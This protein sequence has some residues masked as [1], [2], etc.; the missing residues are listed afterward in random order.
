RRDGLAGVHPYFYPPPFLLGAPIAHVPLTTAYRVWFW[1]DLVLSVVSVAFL[2]AAWGRGR[3]AVPWLL[4]IAFGGA[5]AVANNHGMGQMNVLTLALVA[6]GLAA[7]E[8]DRQGLAGVL[9]GV[10]C[11]AKMS[12]A[13]FVAWWMLRG[14]YKAVGAAVLTGVVLS[15]AAFAVVPWSVQW[16]FYTGVLPG[17]GSGDYNGLSVP[18]GLFG[19]HAL[20]DLYNILLP[21]DGRTLSPVARLLS[22]A[23]LVGVLA[24]M[25][26]AF[27]GPSDAVARSGQAAAVAVAML[28]V[29]VYTYEHHLVWALPAAVVVVDAALSG[30]L[31]KGW[32][33]LALACFFVV[34]FDLETL[35]ALARAAG[36]PWTRV[37]AESKLWALIGLFAASLRL[38]ASYARRPEG[39]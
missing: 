29:P 23:T 10:A 31:G 20:A 30:R 34:A 16:H 37:L 4:A 12:P 33:V 1:L 6:G 36:D 22:T 11:M 28:I 32:L 2:A 21:G 3:P 27:R 5:T 39:T 38:G 24:V 14:R 8:R 15:V 26:V 13:F 9:L 19:N 25:G 7:D 35:R 17:F 18:I